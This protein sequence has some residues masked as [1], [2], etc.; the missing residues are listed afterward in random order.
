MMRG[1]RYDC[2]TFVEREAVRHRLLMT[3]WRPRRQSRSC[4]KWQEQAF[5]DEYCSCGAATMISCINLK[6]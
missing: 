2:D 5:R 4:A 3:R 6:T 1:A